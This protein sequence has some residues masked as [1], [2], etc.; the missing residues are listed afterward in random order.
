M[1]ELYQMDKSILP[2]QGV[3]Y[4][5]GM[6]QKVLWA[7]SS[8]LKAHV[9]FAK[10]VSKNVGVSDRWQTDDVLALATLG[11]A[12]KHRNNPISVTLPKVAKTSTVACR[13]RRCYHAKLRQWKHSLSQTLLLHNK[14]NTCHTCSLYHS[15][16]SAQVLSCRLKFVH[17][18]GGNDVPNVY[19]AIGVY[20]LVGWPSSAVSLPLNDVI[21]AQLACPHNDIIV[22]IR[23]S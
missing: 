1:V 18:Q 5:M 9:T 19:R 23:K 4:Q 8:T 6:N 17:G 11:S 3:R 7:D 21:L 13:Y 10:F 22:N 16:N 2:N 14:T 12:T 15:K 20:F